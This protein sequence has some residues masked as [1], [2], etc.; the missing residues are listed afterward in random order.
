VAARK[1]C[2]RTPQKGSYLRKIMDAARFVI[3]H[4]VRVFA[5]GFAPTPLCQ[6]WPGHVLSFLERHFTY[7]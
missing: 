5:V 7:R 1:A 4:A 2:E 3:H 6:L